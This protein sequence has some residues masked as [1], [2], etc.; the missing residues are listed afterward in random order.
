MDS[1][2]GKVEPNCRNLIAPV[3][4]II[5]TT[6]TVLRI[7][8]WFSRHSAI[9]IEIGD[10]V[11]PAGTD[12]QPI[13]RLATMSGN[14]CSLAAASRIWKS[15]SSPRRCL[16]QPDGESHEARFKR[17]RRRS[18][19]SST[20]HLRRRKP[21]AAFA[22]VR[23][24]SRNA[25]F[26]HALRRSRCARWHM[27][28]LGGLRYSA[29]PDGACARRRAEHQNEAGG[30]RFSEGGL[31]RSVSTSRPWASSLSLPAACPLDGPTSGEVQCVLP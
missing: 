17:L 5:K 4:S 7:V 3:P 20:L 12:F 1:A 8:R 25:K 29:G 26:C 24:A 11:L 14:R 21:V 22:M 19:N 6:R 27:A 28:S 30:Q 18:G 31:W 10:T 2:S 15:S 9:S 16:L 13:V 23:R